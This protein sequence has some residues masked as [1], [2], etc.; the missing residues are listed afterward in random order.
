MPSFLV[1]DTNYNPL[2]NYSDNTY[3]YIGK[4]HLADLHHKEPEPHKIDKYYYQI[5]ESHLDY[6][7]RAKLLT[8]T[9]SEIAFRILWLPLNL[10]LRTFI[11]IFNDPVIMRKYHESLQALCRIN[12]EGSL[13]KIINRC[14][15]ISNEFLMKQLELNIYIY[16]SVAKIFIKTIEEE[17]AWDTLSHFRQ[18]LYG[19]KEII[20]FTRDDGTNLTTQNIHDCAKSSFQL[21]DTNNYYSEFILD[22]KST[23]NA[24][25]I[26]MAYGYYFTKQ[27]RTRELYYSHI[28]NRSNGLSIESQRNWVCIG[29]FVNLTALI[30]KRIITSRYILDP[31]RYTLDLSQLFIHIRALPLLRELDLSNCD[32]TTLPAN[33]YDLPS[34]LTVYLGGNQLTQGTIDELRRPGRRGPRNVHFGATGLERSLFTIPVDLDTLENYLQA[35]YKS[36]TYPQRLLQFDEKDTKT[37][38]IWLSKRVNAKDYRDNPAKFDLKV[39]ENLDWLTEETDETKIRQA[40]AL[41]EFANQDCCDEYASI[42]NKLSLLRKKI[43]TL[44]ELKDHLIIC[45]RLNLIEKITKKKIEELGTCDPVEVHLAYETHLNKIFKLDLP[46]ENMQ[47]ENYSSITPKDIKKA[48]KDIQKKTD[49]EE[50]QTLILSKDDRWKAHIEKQPNFAQTKKSCE[51]Q[52]KAF[53]RDVI[54]EKVDDD[55]EELTDVE[56]QAILAEQVAHQDEFNTNSDTIWNPYWILTK[57]ILNSNLDTPINH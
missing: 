17:F 36:P 22:W 49:G 57:E 18:A 24:S 23:I 40:F 38:R 25:L 10:N 19:K 52:E 6:T 16:R 2:S 15:T 12:L 7:S 51:E 55:D 43:N 14:V 34:N 29:S 42:F 37:L 1:L 44:A 5:N 41:F 8:R 56:Y 47:F 4:G 32:I 33:F 54:G 31:Y 20:C 3:S 9:I 35:V 13:S 27:N 39:K 46:I 28:V 11:V 21:I 53:R 30:V 26:I 45:Y 50:K 48:K